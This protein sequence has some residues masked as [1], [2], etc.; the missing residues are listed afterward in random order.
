LWPRKVYRYEIYNEFKEIFCKKERFSNSYIS[1]WRQTWQVLDRSLIRVHQDK[2]NL[3]FIVF[4][5]LFR[6]KTFFYQKTGFAKSKTDEENDL[7]FKE[8]DEEIAIKKEKTEQ[9]PF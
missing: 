6:L 9:I 7:F 2:N 4:V 3:R 1:F 8:N 5:D